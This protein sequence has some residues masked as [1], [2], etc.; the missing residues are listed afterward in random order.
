[1]VVYRRQ[2]FKV[3]LKNSTS[4]HDHLQTEGLT[5]ISRK[6]FGTHESQFLHIASCL[7]AMVK[8]MAAVLHGPAGMI[9]Q[10]KMDRFAVLALL[11]GNM[12]TVCDMGLR[13]ACKHLR[14]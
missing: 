13:H 9:F 6:E 2:F 3:G 12:Q 8:R 5:K 10:L 7:M 1:M 14:M 4:H 11:R